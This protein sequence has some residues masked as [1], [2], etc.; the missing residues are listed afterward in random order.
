MQISKERIFQAE[1]ISAKTMRW[2][3]IWCVPGNA[4]RQPVQMEGMV[5]GG[6]RR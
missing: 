2:E 4:R 3:H 6:S 5:R 1:E